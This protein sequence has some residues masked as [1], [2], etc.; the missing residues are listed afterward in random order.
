MKIEAKVIHSITLDSDE[1]IALSDYLTAV[2]NAT[3]RSIC[4]TVTCEGISC[5]NC[6]LSDLT[7][8]EETMYE[9]TEAFLRNYRVFQKDNPNLPPIN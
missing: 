7:E 4:E 5:A 6:P 8:L 9:A 2:K 3:K 1:K